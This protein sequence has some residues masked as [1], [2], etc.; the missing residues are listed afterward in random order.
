[1]ARFLV[2]APARQALPYGLFS[3]VS[4]NASTDSHWEISGIE[5]ESI[6]CSSAK[7]LDT[8]CD[9]ADSLTFNSAMA[10]VEQ[11]SFA[12][13]G[14][15]ECS[16]IGNPLSKA[17]DVATARLLA[18]EEKAVESAL[19][20]NGSLGLTQDLPTGSVA[21]S[22][23]T[24]L[25]AVGAKLGSLES[26][27]AANYGS[28]GVI[29]M[30]RHLALWL[31]GEGLLTAT[32]TR[33]FTALG[34]PVVAGSGYGTINKDRAYVT[35]AIVAYR[36]AVSTSTQ[37]VGDNLKTA[38]NDLYGVAERTYSIGWDSCPVGYIDFTN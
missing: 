7:T 24:S 35:P 37:R 19:W 21:A 12:V 1:M 33:L 6:G 22:G 17:T 4:F 11:D 20:G 36:S 27:N 3:V 13:Y 26:F 29:H 34:T 31:L 9:T 14:E 8:D 23:L 16:P 5:F 38:T 28:T 10:L 18:G 32:G 15:Y 2:D 30:P 25:S